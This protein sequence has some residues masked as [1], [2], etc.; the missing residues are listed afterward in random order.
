MNKAQY[1]TRTAMLLAVA[2]VFQNLRILPALSPSMPYSS[3][4]IGTLVN[5]TLIM[6]VDFVGGGAAVIIGLL[7]PV[8]ALLQ[9]HIPGEVL[10]PV[11]AAGN[12]LFALFYC[13]LKRFN[14]FL[15]IAVGAVT[16]FVFLFFTVPAVLSAFLTNLPEAQRN[17]VSINFGWPQ[18]VTALAGGLLAIAVSNSVKNKLSDAEKSGK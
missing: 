13:Y 3:Y 14:R 10:V 17:M 2:V 18:L 11:V 6:S 8:V 5:L 7:A 16:K 4:V 12:I 1:L 15:G 9:H